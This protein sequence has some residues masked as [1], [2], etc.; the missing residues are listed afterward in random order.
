MQLPITTAAAAVLSCLATTAHAQSPAAPSEAIAAFD[1]FVR[2]AA[3]TCLSRPATICIDTG[4]SFADRNRDQGLT[5]AEFNGLRQELQDWFQWRQT[6]LTPRERNALTLA[7]FFV[8]A[9]GTAQIVAGFDGDQDGRVTRAELLADVT[10]DDR[11]LGEVLLD[12]A[13]VDRPAVIRRLGPAAAFLPEI[14]E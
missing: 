13:A 8:D 5:Q 11:P 12:P 14:A 7:L 2:E 4:W 6:E 1:A 9:V 3:P 10:L